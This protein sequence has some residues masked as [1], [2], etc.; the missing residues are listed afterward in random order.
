MD[1]SVISNGIST[2][3]DSFLTCWTDLDHVRLRIRIH[4]FSYIFKCMVQ[5]PLYE[6]PTFPS[7]FPGLAMVIRDDLEGPASQVVNLASPQMSPSDVTLTS[8][9]IWIDPFFGACTPVSPLCLPH[10][11]HTV[12]RGLVHT[13]YTQGRR[14]WYV[15][16]PCPPPGG[17]GN[18]YTWLT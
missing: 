6:H 7:P 12:Q 9:L 14:V 13:T 15:A 5:C 11:A 2:G 8:L 1:T 4:Y 17:V 18:T 10:I 16:G 3:F